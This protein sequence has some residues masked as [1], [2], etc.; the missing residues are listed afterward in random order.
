MSPP[1]LAIHNHTSL[2]VKGFPV[3]HQCCWIYFS[4]HEYRH[5]KPK[6]DLVIE[7]EIFDFGYVVTPDHLRNAINMDTKSLNK[8]RQKL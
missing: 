6:T 1:L 3:K 4:C 7:K 2:R 5:N 8:I